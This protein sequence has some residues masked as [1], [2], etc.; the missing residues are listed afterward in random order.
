MKLLI[1][2]VEYVFGQKL[3]PNGD[4]S[5]HLI[6]VK[7]LIGPISIN[8]GSKKLRQ[9]INYSTIPS[10]IQ[11][12]KQGTAS[13][14]KF[15]SDYNVSL[16]PDEFIKN[17]L[18]NNREF[19]RDILAEFSHYFI[20]TNSKSHLSAFVFIYR[21]LERMS[22]SFP[23]L[24][25]KKEIDFFGTFQ[26]LKNLFNLDSSG[27]HALFKK[28]LNQGKFI[29]KTILDTTYIIDFSTHSN[30]DIYFKTMV[31]LFKSFESTDPS[32]YQLSIKFREIPNLLIIIRN[33]FFHL[34][35][36]DGKNNIAIKNFGDPD[37]FFLELN[38]TFCSF[39]AVLV[40]HILT[41]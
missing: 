33:R 17:N 25:C 27:E 2:G 37:D 38:K 28:F 7:L 3:P 36:G 14:K 16:L 29:D 30:R 32:T 39:L 6:L 35:T 4:K 24:Y 18:P 21:L 31:K 13:F 22:Y 19:F 1:D 26:D 23:L 8:Y 20:Q 5:I 12:L 41:I 40:L 34:R 9:K 11:I 15:A 10:S